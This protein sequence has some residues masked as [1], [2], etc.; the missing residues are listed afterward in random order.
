MSSASDR[1]TISCRSRERRIV[2]NRIRVANAIGIRG[3]QRRSKPH[4]G[5]EAF[6][7]EDFHDNNSFTR[8]Q[9]LTTISNALRLL[10]GDMDTREEERRKANDLRGPWDHPVSESSVA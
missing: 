8:Q 7:W 5:G 1:P 10:E 4:L 2:V 9:K 6:F 3:N